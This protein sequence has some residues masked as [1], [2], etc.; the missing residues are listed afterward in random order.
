MYKQ[1]RERKWSETL[2]HCP[3]KGKR[4]GKTNETLPR[5]WDER[6]RSETLRN[7]LETGKRE[8]EE[9]DTF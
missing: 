1:G 3:E 6:G 5:N 2:R 8:E 4:E 9:G 7:L